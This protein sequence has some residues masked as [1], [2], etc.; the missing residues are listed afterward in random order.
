MKNK[1]IRWGILGAGDVCEVK[2][3]PAF[4]RAEHSEL[5]AVMRRDSTKAED[6]ARRH[7]VGRWY[8]S[9]SDLLGDPEVNAVYIATPPRFHLEHT[10]AALAADRVNFLAAIC[11]IRD[12][13][14]RRH[15]VKEHARIVELVR[16]KQN[17]FLAMDTVRRIPDL[18]NTLTGECRPA[19]D[20]FPFPEA[21]FHLQ[22]DLEPPAGLQR[23]EP[24]SI[25]LRQIVRNARH[26]MCRDAIE[27][28]IRAEFFAF[29]LV[30]VNNVN[31]VLLQLNRLDLCVEPD[32]AL[33]ISC[34]PF[35]DI[36]HSA[37]RFQQ[38]LT[39]VRIFKH[40]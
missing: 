12:A 31:A 32:R 10:L 20:A 4:Q 15:A 7:G 2:S 30:V 33:D 27:A 14:L 29:A 40:E 34:E 9:V 23:F 6:F 16:A 39:P 11:C 25:V 8:D 21:L 18:A 19:V 38:R 17:T 3:G 28:I 5:V 37:N 26:K 22:A 1:T 35:D 24:V 13:L 36:V